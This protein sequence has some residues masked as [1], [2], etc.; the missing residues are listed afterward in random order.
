LIDSSGVAVIVSLFKR[1][2]ATGGSL[3]VIGLRD[4]PRA[5]FE[6][7]CLDRLFETKAS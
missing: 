5:I 1:S 7:L 6:L 2:R 4:Q 3:R